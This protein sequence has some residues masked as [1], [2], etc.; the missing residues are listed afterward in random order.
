MDRTTQLILERIA[1]MEVGKEE[2]KGGFMTAPIEL[3]KILGFKEAVVLQKIHWWIL[4]NFTK[5]YRH[6]FKNGYWWTTC[7]Q[8]KWVEQLP[9]FG[10]KKTFSRTIKRLRELGLI[11]TDVFNKGCDRTA[12]YRV[13]IEAFEKLLKIGDRRDLSLTLLNGKKQSSKVKPCKNF[14]SCPCGQNGSM[15]GTFCPHDPYIYTQ[16]KQKGKEGDF[17]FQERE[18]EGEDSSYQKDGWEEK[19]I[20][21]E[22]KSSWEE[23]GTPQEQ[24]ILGEEE[25]TPQEEIIPPNCPK[26]NKSFHTLKI[27]HEGKCSAAAPLPQP[28]FGKSRQEYTRDLAR[29]SQIPTT[30]DREPYE[31]ERKPGI[32]IE[33]FV[34]DVEKG[35]QGSSNEGIRTMAG[36]VALGFIYKFLKEEDPEQ[37]A[38]LFTRTMKAYQ[39]WLDKTQRALNTALQI[40]DSGGTVQL[41]EALQPISPQATAATVA[42]KMQELM[43]PVLTAAPEQKGSSVVSSEVAITAKRK[44][45]GFSIPNPAVKKKVSKS[46][47]DWID[48]LSQRDRV[49]AFTSLLDIQAAAEWVESNAVLYDLEVQSIDGVRSIVEFQPIG[50]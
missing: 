9:N 39:D 31:F 35:F 15:E 29:N 7:T 37:K 40:R 38:V 32:P 18:E 8:A 23:E 24:E 47:L 21:Q 36:T 50:F 17:S 48:T 25:D 43:Q 3:S 44:A 30:L 34:R 4:H 46:L 1:R 12:W 6:Y 13:D 2:L 10:S 20:S 19:R 11:V 41:P 26:I 16:L 14:K 27:P 28:L 45:L 22:E 49:T 42:Q 5:D 33:A